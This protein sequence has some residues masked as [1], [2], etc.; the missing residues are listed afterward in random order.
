MLECI[1][2]RELNCAWAA[3]DA[4]N[5]AKVRVGHTAIRL[6]VGSDVKG[7]EKVPTELDAVFAVDRKTFFNGHIDVLETGP[8][9]R[10]RTNIAEV[11]C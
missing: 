11:V 5:L 7:I 6:L 2:Q 10:G 3:V 1:P 8:G 9:K 4:G